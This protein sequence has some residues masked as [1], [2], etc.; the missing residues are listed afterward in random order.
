MVEIQEFSYPSANGVHQVRATR[1]VP[2]EKPRAILQIAHGL[3]EYVGRYNRFANYLAQHGILVCGNDHLGHGRTAPPHDRGY[4]SAKNGWNFLVQD[5]ETLR[6][7]ESVRNPGIPYFFLGHSMGSFLLRTYLIDYPSRVAGAILSGTGQMTPAMVTGG[8]RLSQAE[9]IRLG[10]R[11]DSKIL[12]NMSLGGYNKQFSPARTSADWLT[13]DADIVDA[14][15]KDPLC[16]FRPKTGLYRDLSAGLSYISHSKNLSKMNPKT[17]IFFLSGDCDP[18][19]ENGK[20][21]NRAVKLFVKAG[22]INL[23]KT[24]YPGGRHEMVNEINWMQVYKDILT[25]LE[26]YI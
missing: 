24:L 4:L 19:G 7:I 8:V 26:T 25:W 21:V 18:V 14:Y 9:C 6:E 13:R 1:W 20:G 5:M 23:T 22:C 12:Y 11:G 2:E 17:P 15:L 10:L 16:T 3:C